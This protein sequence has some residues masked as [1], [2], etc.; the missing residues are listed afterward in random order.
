MEIATI[1]ETA[2]LAGSTV[3]SLPSESRPPQSD[4]LPTR[5]RG[6][7]MWTRPASEPALHAVPARHLHPVRRFDRLFAGARAMHEVFDVL[8]AS[9]RWTS[10]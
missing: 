4:W 3:A 7:G 2:L 1:A 8:G 5:K 9:P 10:P 6:A